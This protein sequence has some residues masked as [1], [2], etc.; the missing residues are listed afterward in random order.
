MV[1]HEVNSKKVGIRTTT[2]AGMSELLTPEESF[3]YISSADAILEASNMIDRPDN[4]LSFFG[5]ANYTIADKYLFTATMRADASSRFKKGNQWGYF[6]SASA[7]WRMS[8]EEFMKSADWLSNL[9]WRLSYGVAGNN[10]VSASYI[11][12][13]KSM[14]TAYLEPGTSYWTLYNASR[15]VTENL[16][17]ETTYTRNFGFDYGILNGRINGAVDLY[18]NNTKD[19]LLY[20]PII[21]TGY[22]E[23]PRNIGE[24]SN[25]GIEFTINAVALDKHDYGLDFSFNVGWNK[26]RVEDLGGLQAL[27]NT[28]SGW[29]SDITN[30]YW[31]QLG[32][33]LGQIYGYVTEGFYTTDDFDDVG[34]QWVA[35]PGVVDNE[36]NTGT[37]WGPGALKLK[38]ISGPNG[39]PDGKISDDDMQVIGNVLPKATGG[40]N[41]NGR[42]KG[43]DLSA[44]F[45]WSYGNDVYNANKIEFT[46]NSNGNYKYRNMLDIM[47]SSNRWTNIDPVTGSVVT[48][49][50]QLN[51]LNKNAT[52]WSPNTRFINHSWAVEDGSFIRLN[53]LTLGYTLPRAITMKA[54]MQQVRFYASA[55]NLFII[56]NYTGYDPEVDARRSNPLTPGVDYSAYPKSRG[57]NF[58]VNITF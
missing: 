47:N 6:P 18:W 22:S 14:N 45:T 55:T 44:N 52:L 39:E 26:N 8:D 54:L 20:F 57:F 58:G 32:Q 42:Y 48:D 9:K 23:W 50:D 3:N 56:T 29:T 27:S 37:F 7:A 43:F 13:F 31:V 25:K 1:G 40:F 17:W 24:T 28:S 35:R 12:T 53:S 21:G 19:L 36:A 11:H 38:D 15:L 4:M 33:P 16:T 10:D 49:K 2:V 46:S 34:N 41:I 5:R 30:D 51:E